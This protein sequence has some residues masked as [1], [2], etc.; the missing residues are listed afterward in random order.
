MLFL[1]LILLLLLLKFGRF[2][3]EIVTNQKRT[4]L[5]SLSLLF[6][7]FISAF[8]LSRMAIATIFYD[9]Y[10]FFITL[11]L[12]F[13][14][15]RFFSI[16]KMA[17]SVGFIVFFSVYL[18][19]F[20]YLPDTNRD[21]DKVAQYVHQQHVQ[22]IIIVPNYYDITYLYHYNQALFKDVEIRSKENSME[23]YPIEFSE[24]LKSVRLSSK[25]AIIDADFKFTSNEKNPNDWILEKH[26]HLLK[27][28]V[29]KGNYT[30]S[31]YSPDLIR[32]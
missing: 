21:A 30:V 1:A 29:F 27:R 9:R 3:I 15:A 22:S 4:T 16:Q 12:F 11:P 13:I 10:L 2:F 14:L 18:L 23:I 7:P 6:V 24:E 5:V 28:K 19:R 8:L 17:F 25:I 26:Y 32:Q 20:D 31:I